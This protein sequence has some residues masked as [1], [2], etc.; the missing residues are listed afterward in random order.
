MKLAINRSRF[1][2]YGLGLSG[3]LPLF[4]VL[5]AFSIDVLGM[6]F[7][8]SCYLWSFTALT[9]GV[10][11][12]IRSRRYRWSFLKVIFKYNQLISIRM[13][14]KRY[15]WIIIPLLRALA[16]VLFFGLMAIFTKAGNPLYAVLGAL[17]FELIYFAIGRLRIL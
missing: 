11:E 15:S 17:Y 12:R 14:R 2:Y 16:P 3:F 5:W 9:P 6:L 4:L 7:V 10:A 8:T 13:A 1:K